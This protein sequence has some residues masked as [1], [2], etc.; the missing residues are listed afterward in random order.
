VSRAPGLPASAGACATAVG[1]Y[2]VRVIRTKL[3]LVL[4][5]LVMLIGATSAFIGVRLIRDRVVQEAQTRVELDLRSIWS[6]YHARQQEIETILRLAANDRLVA[7]ITGTE[8]TAREAARSRLEMIR[9]RF[10]LDFLTVIDS[11]GRVVLRAAPPYRTG[12]YSTSHMTI[13]KALDGE[14]ATATELMVS[15]ELDRENEGLAETAFTVLEDTPHAR[16]AQKSVETRGMVS[17]AA[18]PLK[19]G[20]EVLGAVYG[21]I[22]LN[23]NHLLVDSM[24]DTVFRGRP[25]EDPDSGTVTIFLHDSRVATTVLLPNGNRAVGTRVSKEVA[26]RVLDSGTRWT[27]RAF[28]VSDWYLTA[29]D[30]IRDGRDRVIGM[31][32]VGILERPF[33]ELTR[34]VLVRFGLLSAV[35]VT[36]ALILAFF[37]S[38]RLAR[39]IHE[40]AE[41]ARR[42][43]A[44]DPPGRV[45]VHKGA[46]EIRYLVGAFNQMA[47]TLLRREASLKEANSKLEQVNDSLRELNQ[48]YME[49]VGFISHE[50]KNP[51]ATMV[52][53]LYLLRELQLGPLTEPQR[54][55]VRTMDRNVR[56]LTE[57]VRHYLDLSRI[58][59]GTFAPVPASVGVVEEVLGPLLESIGPGLRGR[60]MQLE[61]SLPAEILLKVDGNMVREVF[62]NLLSNAVKYGRDGG[63][64][65]ITAE[66]ADGR[67]QFG[68]FNE[69]DG[70]AP[71]QRACLFQKFSRLDTAVTRGQ[72]GTGLG[73]FITRHIVEAHGGRISVESEPGSWVEF[74]FDL[75]VSAPPPGS[76]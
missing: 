51:L 50:L 48:S 49:T 29:Y 72:K 14:S 34:S 19:R 64:V 7:E 57:M 12:D 11:A 25:S 63:K 40:L 8:P 38:T 36:C 26:D 21:G 5:L 3:F 75:P 37:L 61:T 47:D 2:H 58:E 23:K 67:A 24:R 65:R 15:E 44:G 18:V 70:V 73:L 39:P 69:G 28:V 9:L 32:Y 4:S 68:V 41:A 20:T 55:A 31:L 74:R 66:I 62:E 33:N 59:S 43:E 22:L 53:Y 54:Q 16:A 27:G 45:A 56:L 76:G 71:E 6:V 46:R 30:P 60:D 1:C 13:L 42:M 52:N 35:G 17:I 10:G